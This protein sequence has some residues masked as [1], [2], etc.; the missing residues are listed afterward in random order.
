MIE[1]IDKVSDG[2]IILYAVVI[3]VL[4][5]SCGIN[6]EDKEKEKI[7]SV[8]QKYF[9]ALKVGDW[10]GVYECYLPSEREKREATYGILGFATKMFFGTDI[11]GLLS[12]AENL[13]DKENVFADYKYKVSDVEVF[14]S[15]AD[16]IA[17]IEVYDINGGYSEKEYK[18]NLQ[19]NLVKYDT[20]WYVV[21]GSLADDEREQQK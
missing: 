9:D 8:T 11:S 13:I 21:K 7:Q 17:Y 3:S 2:R 20:D 6:K 1:I 16:A 18:G 14:E 15:E 12:N 19:V 10:D 4:F 5:T